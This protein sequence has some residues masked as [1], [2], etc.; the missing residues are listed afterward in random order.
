MKKIITILL[1][2]INLFSYSQNELDKLVFNKINHYR[3]SNE[4]EKW[5]W[6]NN[7]Y[8]ASKHH[9]K[10]MVSS[11]ELTHN[12]N[13]STPTVGKRLLYYNIEWNFCGENITII[14]IDCVEMESLENQSNLILDSWK[15]SELHNKTLLNPKDY[16][17]VGISCRKKENTTFYGGTS[18]FVT[19]N[20]YSTF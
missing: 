15:K 7:T 5:V 17:Y 11:G 13:S 9:T 20:V 14:A 16:K 12:E 6:D 1:I 2:S 19:L 18:I 4:L 8:N 3:E 10:Y